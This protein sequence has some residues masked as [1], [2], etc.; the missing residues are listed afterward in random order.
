M[1]GGDGG[2]CGDGEVCN[3]LGGVGGV[4]WDSG[5]GGIGDGGVFWGVM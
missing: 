5:V 3:G 2:V 1:E 4:A